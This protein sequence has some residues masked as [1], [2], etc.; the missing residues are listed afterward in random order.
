M[1]EL[2]QGSAIRLY[3]AEQLQTILSRMAR[4]LYGVLKG[5]DPLAV[6][7][8]RR[9]GAPLADMLTKLLVDEHGFDNPLRLDITVK[10]YADDLTVL[11]PYTRIEKSQEFNCT[12]LSGHRIL[13]VDDVVHG[14]YSLAKVVDL[15]LEKAPTDIHIACLVDRCTRVV[16]VHT[17]V[18]GI[19]LQVAT[20]DLIEVSVPPYETEFQ[21]GL[22]QPRTA[23]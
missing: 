21:I 7:G 16:P 8:I 12:D 17:D 15:L 3:S 2:V 5:V 14:G 19:R 10:R 1:A 11:F 6:V 4:E 23:L 18:V 9:R 22:Q 13:V 20:S